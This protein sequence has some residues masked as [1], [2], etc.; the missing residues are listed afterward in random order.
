MASPGCLGAV[1]A[2][3]AAVAIVIRLL[4]TRGPATPPTPE[5]SGSTPTRELEFTRPDDW[6]EYRPAM[7]LTPAERW[8]NDPQRPF[9]LDGIWHYYYLYNADYPEGNGTEWYH[10][11][12]R[13]LVH[14]VDHGVAIEKYE[15]GLGDIETGSAV[16][17]TDNTAGFGEGAVIAVL[18]QQHEGVQRQS[19]FVS[20]DRGYR[21][22]PYEANPVMEN[23][24]EE[25]WRDPKIVWHDDHSEWLMVLPKVTSSGSTS[26]P[27]SSAVLPLGIRT[28]RPRDPRMPRPVPHVD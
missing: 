2:F 16:V 12:S 17:D 26:R 11:T 28:R 5:V 6:S 22:E 14:W 9:L 27:T 20:T 19:L 25:H 10:A 24:G 4:L 7:H 21:F 8:M 1:A 18:T 15:N 23:P 3:I 13:D